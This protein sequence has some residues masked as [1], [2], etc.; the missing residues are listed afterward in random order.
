MLELLRRFFSKQLVAD[1][2]HAVAA[3]QD[4]RA[5]ECGRDKFATCEYRLAREATLKAQAEQDAKANA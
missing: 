5:V 2:P 4:C 1:V 3:C